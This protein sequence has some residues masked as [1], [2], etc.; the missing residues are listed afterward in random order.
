MPLV[1]GPVISDDTPDQALVALVMGG[2]SEQAF[3]ALYRRHSP[4][5]FRMALR[6][7]GNEQD[8]EDTLQETWQR[9]VPKLGSFEWRSALGT[10]LASIAVNVAREAL[11]RRGRWVMTDLDA[12]TIR[13]EGPDGAAGVDLER[14]IATL[15]PGSRAVFV[16]HDVEGF[17]HDEIAEQLGV[18]AGTSKSQL[19][20]A[21][22]AL[23]RLLGKTEV[24]ERLYA[25]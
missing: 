5:L 7:L 18:N 22:R 8:A 9:A 13:L 15:P 23:K 12:D 17:T 4:R 19:F 3:R 11:E 21:R 20:R 6:L 16:L 2:T 1:R 24:E 25:I 10:W 14:A